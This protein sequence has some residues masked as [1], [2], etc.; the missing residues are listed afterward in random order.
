VSCL[1]GCYWCRRRRLL[2]PWIHLNKRI[3][4]ADVDDIVAAAAAAAVVV[5]VVVVVVVGIWVVVT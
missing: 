3:L 4:G 2:P 5:V 1:S